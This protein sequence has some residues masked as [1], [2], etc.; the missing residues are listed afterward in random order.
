MWPGAYFYSLLFVFFSFMHG[1]PLVARQSKE[2]KAA[3]RAAYWG[4]FADIYRAGTCG[5]T[6][7]ENRECV[8]TALKNARSHVAI[9]D[10]AAAKEH[11]DFSGDLTAIQNAVESGNYAIAQEGIVKLRETL[12]R[13][14]ASSIAP[15]LPPDLESGK[16]VFSEY[17]QSCHG[18]GR[19]GDGALT[20]KLRRRPV[21]F[22]SHFLN[23]AQSPFGI[24]GVMIHGVDNSEMAS[25]LDV[26]G[27]DELWSVAFY[28]ASLPHSDVAIDNT[29]KL[30]V[31]VRDRAE[32]FSLSTLAVSS[33]AKL[34]DKLLRGG[35]SCGA[36]VGEIA[37]LRTTWSGGG[38]AGRLG[39]ITK[40]PRQKAESRAL[41]MLLGAIILVSG[42]FI[43]VLRRRGRIE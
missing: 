36:C 37:F 13:E 33:D 10:M 6:S 11:F 23:D 28:I 21:S 27:V 4:L 17:C 3:N 25:M 14:F 42:G 31:W 22:T 1:D 12:I 43:L 34:R 30:S 40:S 2:E 32:D 26:L 41:V 9:V 39:D 20:S 38:M 8:V 18:D 7:S 5:E 24:Y 15:V 19:G 35:L 29:D 16:A